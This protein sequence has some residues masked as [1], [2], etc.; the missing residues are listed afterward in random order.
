MDRRKLAETRIHVGQR[1]LLDAGQIEQ[2][3]IEQHAEI[4]PLAGLLREPAE[5]RQRR[6]PHPVAVELAGGERQELQADL[7]PAAVGGRLQVVH[8]PQRLHEPVCGRSVEAD[9]GGDLR[10]RHATGGGHGLEHVER[11]HQR[12]DGWGNSIVVLDGGCAQIRLSRHLVG[13]FGCFTRELRRPRVGRARSCLEAQ[14]FQI[15]DRSS[16]QRQRHGGIAGEHVLLDDCKSVIAGVG[17]RG[18]KPLEVDRAASRLVG[19]AA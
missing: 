17:Q 19:D 1:R 15:G 5:M 18:G 8:G 7:E 4:D 9:L 11:L 14:L 2:L 13:S 10:H 16:R 12:Q 3:A 6:Q